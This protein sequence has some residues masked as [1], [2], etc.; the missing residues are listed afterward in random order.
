MKKVLF[1]LMIF[2]FSIKNVY[3]QDKLLA[4]N[5][6]SAIIIEAST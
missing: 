6:K 3:A 5:S 2:L 1:F 4:K